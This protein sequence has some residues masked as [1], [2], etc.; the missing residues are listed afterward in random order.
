MPAPPVRC[1]IWRRV[2][3]SCR[4]LPPCRTT[5]RTPTGGSSAWPLAQHRAP[6]PARDAARFPGIG[7]SLSHCSGLHCADDLGMRTAGGCAGAGEPS[8]VRHADA[9][10]QRKSVRG[11]CRAGNTVAVGV[12][13]YDRADGHEIW[14]R[15]RAMRRLYGTYR[16][17]GDALL[18]DAGWRPG[19][20]ASHH[21]RGFG[22]ERQP[23]SGAESLDRVR[24]ATM[25]LLSERHDD[26][27]G[28][29]AQ[30]EA[31]PD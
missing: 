2:T 7:I 4:G 11:G 8:W 10:H 21:D 26:G 15:H 6:V 13:R 5:C 3:T 9:F 12:A 28:G 22:A 17:A 23:A 16:W 1:V 14:L 25:R 30:A 24:R 27:G 18:P 29:T 19:G 20:A 31:E